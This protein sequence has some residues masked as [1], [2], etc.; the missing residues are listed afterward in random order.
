MKKIL[1]IITVLFALCVGSP[2]Y[3]CGYESPKFE[4]STMPTPAVAMTTTV[5]DEAR[6]ETQRQQTETA[7]YRQRQNNPWSAVYINGGQQYALQLHYPP[8]DWAPD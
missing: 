4:T 1:S 5:Y 7:H 2:L 8:V 6:A 3:A